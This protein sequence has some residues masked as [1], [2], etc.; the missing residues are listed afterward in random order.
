MKTNRVDSV[1][2]PVFIIGSPRSGTTILG[3]VLDLHPAVKHW[4]EPY[5]V[6]DRDFRLNKND[7]R[8]VNDATPAVTNRIRKRFEYFRRKSGCRFVLDKAPRNSLRIPF[9]RQ[10]FPRA[11][12]IHIYRDGRDCTLSIHR[13]WLKRTSHVIE[14]VAG[15]E[16]NKLKQW[17]LFLKWLNLQPYMID[18][19]RSLWFETHGHFLNRQVWLSRLR[20]NGSPGWGPRFSGWE[21]AYESMS[22]LQFNAQQW[23]ACVSS[24]LDHWPDIP[25]GL[26]HSVRYEDF[27]LNPKDTFKTILAFV[28]LEYDPAVEQNFLEMKKGNFNKWQTA[29]TQSQIEEIRPILTPGLLRLGYVKDSEW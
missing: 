15:N 6:W 5:F 28:G 8:E 18:R 10:V 25:E 17:A 20:W 19:L 2:E 21:K 27:V 11:R 13:E 24:I 23:H 22:L 9:L 1:E 12:F 14:P 7:V 16:K 3:E 26:K 29:F 4:F